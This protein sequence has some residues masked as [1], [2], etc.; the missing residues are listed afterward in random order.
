[1]IVH[2]ASVGP[3]RRLGGRRPADARALAGGVLARSAHARAARARARVPDEVTG[4]L[5]TVGAAG[6][7]PSASRSRCS[8]AFGGGVA[9]PS[10][11]RFGRVSPTTAD[12]VRA[13]LGD[14]VD[15]VLDG[16]PCRVGVESTIV[17]CTGD[18]PAI[19]RARRRRAR[20]RSRRS[21]GGAVRGPRPTARSRAP[22]TLPSHYAPHARVVVVDAIDGSRA[23]AHVAS[24]RRGA[25]VGVLAPQPSRRPA[26]RT[27][28]CSA[29]RPTPTST[30]ASLYR[31]AARRRRARARRRAGGRRRRSRASAPRSPTGSSRR[32]QPTRR[33]AMRDRD[34]RSACSTPGSA[35]SPCCARSSTCCPTSDIVYF[36]DT[37]RFPYGPKPADEVLKYS[38]E[39]TDLLL[40]ARREDARGRV[41]QRGG[42]RARRARRAPRRSR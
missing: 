11:N 5:D 32:V 31:V 33:A 27:S 6:A 10:A 12:D 38:L 14:D 1:M 37:G 17:D 8:S 20:A 40:A 41:Q 18:A 35:G 39:I 16:G 23:R 13:D 36:G 9:A 42:G 29:R 26:R 4:G 21:L 30:R 2:L 19:L 25:R 28:S 34:R 7:R 24:S 15:V 22:G 3:A